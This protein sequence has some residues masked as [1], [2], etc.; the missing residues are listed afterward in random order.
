[1]KF[2]VKHAI[3][4]YSDQLQI[5]IISNANQNNISCALICAIANFCVIN[6][7]LHRT[8]PY[9]PANLENKKVKSI[10][11]KFTLG[12]L[13]VFRG[14]LSINNIITLLEQITNSNSTLR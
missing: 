3:A 7:T 5:K 11:Y 12:S 6:C 1:M 10:S 13:N 8:S 4:N 2:W 9:D 14:K